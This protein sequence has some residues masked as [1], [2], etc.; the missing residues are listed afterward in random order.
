MISASDSLKTLLKTTHAIK[1]NAGCTIEY[2]MNAM[3]N[4][5]VVSGAEYKTINGAQPFKKLFPVDS[6]VKPVRPE[7]AGIKYYIHGDIISNEWANPKNVEYPIDYR[8]YVPGANTYYKYFITPVGTASNLSIAYPKDI[9]V[10]KITVKFEISHSLPPTWT[11]KGTPANG[12]QVTLVSGTSSDIVPFETNGS[13]NYDAGTVSIYYTGS[14]WSKNESDLNTSAYVSMENVGLSVT[15]SSGE[16]V[17]IIEVAPKYVIDV[18]DSVLSFDVFKESSS[19]SNDALPV[20][21]ISA[22]S[23]SLELN[24]YDNVALKVESYIKSTTEFEA[25]KIYFFKKAEVKPYFKVYHSNGAYGTTDKY[26]KIDQ[27]KFFMDS[28]SISEYGDVKIE[29]LDGAKILQEIICPNMFCESY[30][31]T[32]IIR[33]LLDNIGFT[34]YNINIHPDKALETSV[35][36]PSY[37]WT[38]DSTTV[39]QSLQE[40]CRDTQMTAVF[41]E[42]NVLQFY[43]R[44]Y[45]Y[46]DRDVDWKITY[47]P[48]TEGTSPNQITILPNIISL[49]RNDLPS[50]N[51][52]TVRWQSALT[53]NYIQGSSV[54]WK[55]PISYLG[56]LSLEERIDASQAAGTDS[57]MNLL[58]ILTDDYQDV[59]SLYSYSGYLL[60]NSEIIEYDGIEFEY[61]PI[62]S[63]TMI[64]VLIQ[65][66]TDVFKYRALAKPGWANANDPTTAYFRT[67]GRYR[68]KTRGAFGTTVATHETDSKTIISE[69]T[70]KNI[71]WDGT[72]TSANSA[73]SSIKSGITGALSGT[74]ATSSQDLS[75]KAGRSLFCITNN[76]KSKTD[77]S[78]AYKT[79]SEIPSASASVNYYSFGATMFMENTIDNPNAGGGLAF[80]VGSSA[81][82][83]YMLKIDTSAKSAASNSKSEVSIVK[84]YNGNII[85]I[86]DSQ[87][88]EVKFS[89]VYSGASYRVDIK[90]KSTSAENIIIAYIN[91]YKIVATDTKNEA[92]DPANL[93]VP[94]SKSIG[95]VANEGTIKFDYIY[96]MSL[97]EK[98]YNETALF[99]LYSGRFSTNSI[100]FLFGEK[101]L[102]YTSPETPVNGKVQE[103]GNTAREIRKID[104]KY[105]TRPAY[106]LWPSTGANTF[107]KVIGSRTTP[108]GAEAYVLNNSGTFIPLDDSNNV[109]FYVG[110]KTVTKSGVLEYVD[111]SS[112]EFTSEE[113]VIF[114]SQ[115]LQNNADVVNLGTWIKNQWAKRQMVLDLEVF[116]NPIISVGDV[117]SVKYEYNNL[118]GQSQKFLVTNVSHTYS[119]GLSTTLSCRTL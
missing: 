13:K 22:N 77:Y 87:T 41:D 29:A 38:D 36:S 76:T 105:D 117:L 88:K 91:G 53:S 64:P 97:T 102:N 42:N 16:Y 56:A 118:D 10:N 5:I 9:F 50:K 110:G 67:T 92:A 1:I 73:N 79:F 98:Q 96:G 71:A 66:E 32:A 19:S 25:D 35:I 34:N 26:D 68:I 11:I 94:F 30:S 14:G 8:L 15:V 93:L 20:G 61:E 4:D 80:F 108:F 46:R 40:I 31:S 39:W 104:I 27:G 99:N 24:K 55:S 81:E 21:Y 45:M 49:S 106:P 75:V 44:D 43:T 17:G 23:L 74:A 114:D 52:V 95:M 111:D 58:P 51:K 57:W 7:L 82:S 18:S 69:W 116:G 48:L 59:Q 63:T 101:V 112:N 3:I 85:P 78:I 54:L 89:G 37:W 86:N 83:C 119:E 103:F 6:I 33:R 84:V 47:D 100:N 72:A 107:A 2:N 65:N 60:I 62:D 70:T 115:W 90:V 28:W 109:S 12:S 113:P